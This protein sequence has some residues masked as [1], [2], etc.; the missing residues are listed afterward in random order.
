MDALEP[1]H[2][3]KPEWK[4]PNLA[5]IIRDKPFVMINGRKHYPIHWETPNY[6]D[7]Y[8]DI[9]D[10]EMM[11]DILKLKC[12]QHPPGELP[13]SPKHHSFAASR[14]KVKRSTENQF[15]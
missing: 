14:R 3:Q 10:M 8:I 12:K 15:S 5:Y 13:P 11:E 6:K 9:C 4:C 2:I 1:V 7:E